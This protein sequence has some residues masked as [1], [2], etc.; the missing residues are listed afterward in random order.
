MAPWEDVLIGICEELLSRTQL[1]EV[2][3]R[4]RKTCQ[5]K[6]WSRVVYKPVIFSWVQVK[7]L[8]RESSH[9]QATDGLCK[10]DRHKAKNEI[11]IK[12]EPKILD[13]EDRVINTIR[14]TMER[15][16]DILSIM[17]HG[18]SRVNAIIDHFWYPIIIKIKWWNSVLI[19]HY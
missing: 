4:H 16:E 5:R 1:K 12:E 13:R 10:N 7:P 9:Y 17:L 14:A 6:G 11:I 19:L 8:H 2:V 18:Q 3:V 15:R